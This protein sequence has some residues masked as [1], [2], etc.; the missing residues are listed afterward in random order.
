MSLHCTLGGLTVNDVSQVLDI[1]FKPI[2]GLYAAGEVTAGLHG[3]D[4]L[5]GNGITEAVV[6]GRRAGRFAA[7]EPR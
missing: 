7:G 6:F 4:R 1:D 2:S 3:S 5:G